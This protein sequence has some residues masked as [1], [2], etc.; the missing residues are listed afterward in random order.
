M[1]ADMAG[2]DST[3]PAEL[4]ERTAELTALDE[5]LTAVVDGGEGRL[6][7]VGG[8]AGVGKTE[9]VRRFCAGQGR[10]AS[11]LW[12]ACDALF[13]PR[14]LGPLL[15]VA[16][17]TGGSLAELVASAAR[18]H[19]VAAALAVEL[20][21]RGPAILILEDLHWADEATLDVLRLLGRRVES[22]P[23]LVLGTYR[24]D[25][26]DA[27]HP[28]RMVLGELATGRGVRRLHV[29]PLSPS[30]VASL[31]EPHGV[32]PDELY[33]K[34]GGNAFFVVEA[35]AAGGEELPQ[36]VRDAVLARAARL[37]GGARSVLE[38]VAIAPP[39]VEP[40]L[41]EA[42]AGDDA[43]VLDEALG[44]GMLV[45]A[46]GGVAFRHELAR[47]AVEESIAPN[48]RIA[49][50]RRVLAA[51]AGT[52]DLA[53]LA[54][55][56]EAAVDGEAV[57]RLAPAAGERAACLGAHR[58]AAA[59]Y[60]RALRFA[61]G[62]SAATRGDLLERRA[63][64]SYLTGRFAEAL[65]AQEEAV[66]CYREVGDALREGDALRSLSRVLR[67]AG[68]TQDAAEVGGQAVELLAQL[69]PGRELALAYCH[70]SH[71]Y[72]W[73]EEPDDALA[74]ATRALALGERI[75]DAE[76]SV[77]A[78]L[79]VG[80]AEVIGGDPSGHGTLERAVAQAVAAGFEEHVGRA[81]VNLVWWAPRDRSYVRADRWLAAGLEYCGERG[82]D[83][84][85]L[86]LLAYRARTEL[87]R[88]RW[89]EAAASAAAVLRDPRVSP[90]SRV[91]ALS[92]LG[93]VRARRGDP[94]VWPALDEAW[95]LAAPTGELQRVEPA[96]AAR[97]EALW[98]EGRD[99]EA[100]EAAEPGLA[101]ARRRQAGWAAGEFA[102]W[103]RRAGVVEDVP[104]DGLYAH[105]LA[106]DWSRAAE[107]WRALDSPYEAALA[108]AESDDDA[109]VRR[110]LDELQALGAQ[111]AAAIVTRR[112]RARGARGIPR[113]PRATTRENP[114]LLTPREVEVVALVAEGLRN[115][116]I[117]ERLFL[118]RRTVD[119]HVA[120]ILRKLGVQTRGQ[121]SA[122]AVRLGLAGG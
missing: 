3:R 97:A 21:T 38:A 17:A 8:E 113:G 83:L 98:L 78:L 42:L 4:L 55:H 9:L 6:V 122:E 110:A 120:S 115:S 64:A 14:P 103:R 2:V 23:V 119:H 1:G 65:A 35:L 58:E 19:E 81:Y 16:E 85:R 69:P 90:V 68:R 75:G 10:S 34:T 96:A 37:S 40:R 80:A 24:N 57:L 29:E 22:L 82:L 109:D 117:A 70:V 32:D 104:A 33:R 89:D 46:H 15:D 48:R 30:A 105:D 93:L 36:T 102:W 114:S 77:Y 31:A 28:L 11:V 72:I 26:V 87:D 49:L 39:Q 67:Y 74:W 50:H 108:L 25:E 116:E 118:S 88:G 45:P 60:A 95:K 86:Y 54:H 106:A 63:F 112:L 47:L 53:R 13:T 51:L 56:A 100:A 79:N 91:V 73:A 12:G 76:A 71:L 111:P 121:A 41:L 99:A 27:V 107:Q 18:P 84:W 94:D 61:D 101:L 7:L 59:Q 52:G 5:A 43:S 92:V 66:A 62:A 44:S 20:R